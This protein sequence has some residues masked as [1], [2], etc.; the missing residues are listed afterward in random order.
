MNG[1][2]RVALGA[3][4]QVALRHHDVMYSDVRGTHV[5]RI[6]RVHVRIQT[7]ESYDFITLCNS[8]TLWSTTTL[9]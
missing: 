1:L 4:V 6:A 5:I 7:D 2:K 3:V 8:S 9:Q